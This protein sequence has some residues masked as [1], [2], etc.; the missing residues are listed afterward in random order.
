MLRIRED[1][2]RWWR[3][4]RSRVIP[5]ANKES[6]DYRVPQEVPN[7]K[8]PNLLG[9]SGGVTESGP[10]TGKNMDLT[11]TPRPEGPEQQ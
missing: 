8:T 2:P 1:I 3:V 7:F 4:N 11:N 6:L 9:F 5:N 10:V